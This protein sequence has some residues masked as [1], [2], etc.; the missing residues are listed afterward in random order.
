MASGAAED[1]G[2]DA[3]LVFVVLLVNP[4]FERDEAVGFVLIEGR[5]D[6]TGLG[7]ELMEFKRQNCV[8]RPLFHQ[9]LIDGTDPVQE[10]SDS[11]LASGLRIGRRPWRGQRLLLRLEAACAE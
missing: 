1:V 9:R 7:D 2:V 11:L 8:P 6:G 4:G 10:I 3:L 5:V